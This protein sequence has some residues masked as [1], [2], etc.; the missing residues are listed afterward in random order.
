[1]YYGGKGVVVCDRWHRFD[2]FAFDIEK[3]P[4]FDKEKFDNRK[5]RLDKDLLSNESKIYSPETT[6]WI[7]DLYN[8]KIRAEEYNI[9]NKKFAIFP[10]GHIEQILHV[11]DFCKQYGLHRQNVNNCLCGKQKESKGFKFYKE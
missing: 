6:V 11:S 7:S 2:L 4:G 3:I 1:M 10:D 5:L 8:Q 9:K